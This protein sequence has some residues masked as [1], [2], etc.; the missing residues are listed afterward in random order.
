LGSNIHTSIRPT[1]KRKFLAGLFV[2]IP[3][4]ITFL[5]IRWFFNFVDSFLEPFYFNMLGYHFP[6]IGFI[7]AIIIIFLVGIISTNVFGKRIIDSLE[8][9][10]LKIPVLK[11]IYTSV[12]QLVEA[13][14]PESKVSSFKKF[15]IVEYPRQGTFSYGFLTKDCVIKAE[16]DG[17]ETCLK[18]V[19]IPTNLIYFGDIVLFPEEHVFFTDIH[20]QEG[21]KIIL[22]GGIATPSKISGEK[23]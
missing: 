7:S 10:L 4:V 9:L 14:S 8:R 17:R 2:L 19:Y 20:I 3:A 22:S 21:I 6:G 18:A 11:G 1:L 15:V 5:V 16:K 13:F 12:K 23:G